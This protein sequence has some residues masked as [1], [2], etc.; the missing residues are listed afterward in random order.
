[1]LWGKNAQEKAKI[2]TNKYHYILE[3]PHPSPLSARKGFYGC[4]H[5]SKSNNILKNLDKK[6]IDWQIRNI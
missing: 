4:E 3:A 1:L 5:F 2:I 6:V